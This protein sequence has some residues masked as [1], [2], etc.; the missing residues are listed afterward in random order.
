MGRVVA[1]RKGAGR[2]EAR[3]RGGARG[4][5]RRI[6]APA[7]RAE[8]LDEDEGKKEGMPTLEGEW[9]EGEQGLGGRGELEEENGVGEERRT[10]A[11]TEVQWSQP[12]E[13]QPRHWRWG[14]RVEEQKRGSRH[15]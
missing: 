13:Q 2:R 11:R 8:E 14:C 10:P 4:K 1:D 12:R 15:P 5:E 3:G 7:G 9:D 6:A